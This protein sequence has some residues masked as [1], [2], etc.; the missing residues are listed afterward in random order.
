MMRALV[1]DFFGTL[2]DPGAEADRR[3]SFGA[4]AEALEV[5][6]DAFW[7]AMSGSFGERV[8][9]R[10]G[11]T[12]DPLRAMA[13]RCGANPTDAQLDA[14]VA[15]H[16]KGAEFLRP[17]RVGALRL[18]DELRAD[19][20]RIG[21]IS[22]CSS[23]LCEAWTGTPY[24]GRIDTAV[25]SWREGCR[26]PDRRLYAAASRRLGVPAAECWF[27]GDGGGREHD[28]ARRA[29]MRP[30]LVTNA[31]YPGAAAHRADPDP[32]RPE[33]VIDDL[34]ELRNLVKAR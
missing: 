26:K 8:V 32:Y 23:E 5:P 10:Y 34:D 15:V 4:T 33:D 6:E 17:P 3:S 25:F 29:G 18:L 1:F 28:G 11:G 7:L 12:R 20:F 27:V 9:G 31:R 22:D 21:L 13:A 2:T 24:A 19:G 16:T 30:V 14:A